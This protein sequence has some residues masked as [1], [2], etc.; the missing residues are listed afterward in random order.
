MFLNNVLFAL[1]CIVDCYPTFLNSYDNLIGKRNV[2]KK[3]LSLN[4]LI[5]QYLF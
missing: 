3:D 4:F 1:S 2:F 5:V